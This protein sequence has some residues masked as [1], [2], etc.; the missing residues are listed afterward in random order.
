VMVKGEGCFLYI[1]N[2]EIDFT[3]KCIRP[4]ITLCSLFAASWEIERVVSPLSVQRVKEISIFLNK[5]FI[6]F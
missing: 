5:C 3:L 1:I 4:V 2:Y 6:K